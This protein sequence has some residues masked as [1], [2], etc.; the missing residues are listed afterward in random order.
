MKIAYF[1]ALFMCAVLSEAAP[2]QTIPTACIN[3]ASQLQSSCSK[4]AGQAQSILGQSA[5]DEK[6]TSYLNDPLNNP[7]AKCC[8]AFN[9]FNAAACSCNTPLMQLIASYGLTPKVYQQFGRSVAESCN[10][11]LIY[12]PTC[13]TS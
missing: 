2:S 10:F 12:G 4:E 7:S 3:A 5:S 1:T 13:P 8:I 11:K 9:A 6:V